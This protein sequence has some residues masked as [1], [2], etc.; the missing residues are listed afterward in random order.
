LI[1]QQKAA[2]KLPQLFSLRVTYYLN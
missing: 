2:A 1:N